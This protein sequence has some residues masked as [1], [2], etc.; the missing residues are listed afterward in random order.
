MQAD[1]TRAITRAY[2]L[3]A[4]P[5]RAGLDPD[6]AEA[7]QMPLDGLTCATA[8]E[9]CEL[10]ADSPGGP[11]EPE[12]FHVALQGGGNALG[13]AGVLIAAQGLRPP[14]GTELVCSFGSDPL[15]AAARDGE[16]PFSLEECFN[17]SAALVAWSSEHGNAR[18]VQV[19]A[20]A[21]HDAGAD[22]VLELGLMLAT[23]VYY[24]RAL[25]ARGADPAHPSC[26]FDLLQ[27]LDADL[28]TGVA[29]LRAARLCWSGVLRA[30][31]HPEAARHSALH[32]RASRRMLTRYDPLVNLLRLSS[33]SLAS[34]FGGADSIALPPHDIRLAEQSA[35]ARRWACDVPLI[36][37]LEA[38]VS[39][40]SDP[41]GGA[42]YLEHLSLQIARGAWRVLQEIEALGG[43]ANCL[44]S[45]EVQRRVAQAREK[46]RGL[47]ETLSLRITGITDHPWASETA[48]AEPGAVSD[49]L[50]S[51]T[52]AR[53]ARL[54]GAGRAAASLNRLRDRAGPALVEAAAEAAS[55]GATLGEI[56][57]AIGARQGGFRVDPLAPRH[58]AD[59]F[60]MLRDAAW[61]TARDRKRPRALVL[62]LPGA[63]RKREAFATNVLAMAP[64]DVAQ[65]QLESTS[66]HR[67]SAASP[68]RIRARIT[69]P[70]RAAVLVCAQAAGLDLASLASNLR[71]AGAAAVVWVGPASEV[72][73]EQ[74]GAFDAFLYEGCNV[75]RLLERLLRSTGA[76]I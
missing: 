31:G 62:T 59:A 43:M 54:L 37:R 13:L 63:D 67:A 22:A 35:G 11:A 25:H 61:R 57:A 64:F 76:R 17:H 26:G 2:L 5:L 36:Q 30:W 50:R 46:R 16:L 41:G 75:C 38:H 47:F 52:A 7:G 12:P 55:A 73:V 71:E 1:R 19:D 49:D 24:L 58:D 29:K 39:R 15:T 45:G 56:A 8:S 10:L 18:C 53:L 27:A 3:F 69:L 42:F 40:V 28:F 65:M 4:R 66:W 48:S 32:A 6:A 23:G 70:Q 20:T 74:Q 9:L 44:V 21:Y 14:S 33:A 51:A 72:G 60:E 34:A 68:R